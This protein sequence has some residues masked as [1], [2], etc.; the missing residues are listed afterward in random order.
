MWANGGGFQGPRRT[1]HFAIHP[2]G[3]LYYVTGGNLVSLDIGLGGGGSA[4]VS[5]TPGIPTVLGDGSV[6]VPVVTG[7]TL[8]AA[9]PAMNWDLQDLE[10]FRFQPDLSLLFLRPGHRTEV[11]TVPR[12][13]HLYQSVVRPFK[14]IPNGQG[15]V[16][17]GWDSDTHFGNSGEQFAELAGLDASGA[18]LGVV[19]LGNRWGEMVLTGRDTIVATSF[20]PNATHTAD[21]VRMIAEMTPALEIQSFFLDAPLEVSSILAGAD[22]GVIVNYSDGTMGGPDPGY[23][24]MRLTK[25]QPADAG[26]WLGTWNNGAAETIAGISGVCPRGST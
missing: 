22:G 25:A 17:L 15:G 21:V 4:S 19:G 9:S 24:Q 7:H 14:A 1:G 8:A 3:P 6:V 10:A 20:L 23:A 11:Q 16:V 12:I 13:G 5:G 2:D 18:A 26:T